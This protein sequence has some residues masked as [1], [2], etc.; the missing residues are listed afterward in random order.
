MAEKRTPRAQGEEPDRFP[1]R[2][3]SLRARKKPV[4]S[5]RVTSELMGFHANTLR[6]YE[7]GAA[8]PSR[9]HLEQIADYY[10]VSI[11]YLT[12]RTDFPFVKMW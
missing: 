7:R 8:D 6:S 1:T 12:G 2:L 9:R 11:D 3:A 5:A 10:G 4:R